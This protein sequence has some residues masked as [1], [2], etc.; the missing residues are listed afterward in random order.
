MNTGDG[1]YGRVLRHRSACGQSAGTGLDEQLEIRNFTANEMFNFFYL[2]E[3]VKKIK[4][5]I[6][7]R[8]LSRS[9]QLKNAPF[10]IKF[11][12][13]KFLNVD[14]N[15]QNVKLFFAANYPW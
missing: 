13:A 1:D 8:L 10:I 3:V 5:E 7:V 14:F 4:M 2:R 9:V 12:N 6:K 15:I 11:A